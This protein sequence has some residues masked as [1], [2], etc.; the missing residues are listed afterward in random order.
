MSSKH[1]SRWVLLAVTA[2]LLCSA[3]VPARADSAY[4]ISGYFY[5]NKGA[6]LYFGGVV[7]WNATTHQVSGYT[8]TLGGSTF[9]CSGMICGFVSQT[10]KGPGYREW[11]VGSLNPKDTEFRLFGEGK[12]HFHGKLKDVAWIQSMPDAPAMAELLC[13]L[14]LL[15]LMIP[16][17]RVLRR[18]N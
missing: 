5:N 4:N 8:L 7:D 1:H 6:E 2:L 11:L 13:V 16:G 18:Q 12:G 14:M 10:F 9:S 17:A 3:A 15:G